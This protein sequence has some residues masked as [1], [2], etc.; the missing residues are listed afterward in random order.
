MTNSTEISIDRI[1]A[2]RTEAA[3]AGDLEAVSTCDLAIDGD[4]GAVSVCSRWASDADAQRDTSLDYD[5]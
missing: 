1:R 3:E 4:A 5:Y 2:M